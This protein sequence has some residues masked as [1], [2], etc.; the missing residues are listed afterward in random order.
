MKAKKNS[1]EY[2]SKTNFSQWQTID[3]TAVEK[4][5]RTLQTRIVK[6]YKA[7]QFRKV[8]SLQWILTNSYEAKLLAVKRVTSNKGSRTSGVD[9]VTWSTDTSKI[10]AI[11][12]LNRKS[13]KLK[14]LKR[15]YI[16]KSNGKQRP[17]SIPC[18]ID[19]AM[20]ALYL[21]ALD[22]IAE[23][24][25]DAN[26]YGFRPMRSCA[27]AIEQC[28]K[29]LASKR[30]AQWIL[31]ADIKGCFDNISH[32]WLLQNI[33]TDK[34][35]LRL[36]LKSK[37]IDGKTLFYSEQGTPQGGI[38]SPVLANFV[39]NG[40]EKVL[41]NVGK[42]THYKNGLLSTNKH[43]INF[44]RYADDFIITAN[45]KVFIEEKIIPAIEAFLQERGLELSKEKTRIVNI[46]QGFNFL[47][48]NVRK[49][50]GK[51]LIKPS[52]ENI[53]SVKKKIDNIIH[54]CRAISQDILIGQLNPVIRGWANYHR[55]VVAKHSFRLLDNHV[56]LRLWRWAKR[57]HSR[58]SAKWVKNKYFHYHKNFEWT[59]MCKK[60]FYKLFLAQSVPIK[61]HVKIRGMANPYDPLWDEYFKERKEKFSRKPESQLKLGFV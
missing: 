53:K 52:K 41:D 6:A 21:L 61:R 18:M 45:D 17:L 22:P 30:S 54:K 11:E 9:K 31:D 28:Y 47:G 32:D 5:V 16:P 10:K 12:L 57:R 35:L 50:K 2:A 42:R 13:Y 38:I 34:R 29:T 37:V 24:Q 39:L 23:T 49:Y 56:H 15:I 60:S 25:A 36:W 48:Q 40:I 46:N 58:K 1:K 4:R 59:F 43:L 51:L 14:P 3:W 55:R 44:T 26:S 27:D 7:K 33:P 8:R 19:R 20:Q